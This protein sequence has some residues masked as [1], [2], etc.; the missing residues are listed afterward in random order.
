MANQIRKVPRTCG[1]QLYKNNKKLSICY[2][3]LKMYL[4]VHLK[5]ILRGIY[6]LFRRYIFRGGATPRKSNFKV[7]KAAAAI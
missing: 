7:M 1:D 3:E 4:D 2:D 6:R 5:N